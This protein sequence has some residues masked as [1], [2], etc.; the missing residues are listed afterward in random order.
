[1]HT[2]ETEQ[3]AKDYWEAHYGERERIWSGRVNVQLAEGGR[4]PAARAA[5]STWAAARAATP[6]GWP[7]TAGT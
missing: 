3:N 6:S 5:H 7:S 4:G 2:P 1:M